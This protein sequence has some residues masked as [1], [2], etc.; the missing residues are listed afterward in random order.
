MDESRGR[1][2]HS[3]PTLTPVTGEP[4]VAHDLRSHHTFRRGRQEEL[5]GDT[6]R[7][8]HSSTEAR[9]PP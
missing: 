9:A 6:A 2:S 5:R 1:G 3:Q 4:Q 8:P 7:T